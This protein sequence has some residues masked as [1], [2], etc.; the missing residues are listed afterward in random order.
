MD[1]KLLKSQND[2]VISGMGVIILAVWTVVKAAMY[3]VLRL[4]ELWGTLEADYRGIVIAVSAGVIALIGAVSLLLR[5]T[6]GRSAIREGKGGKSGKLYI[7]LA[8]IILVLDGLG[9]LIDLL[10]FGSN[11]ILD[12]VAVLAVD[13]TSAATLIN[14]LVSAKRIRNSAGKAGET[15]CS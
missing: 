2:L 15:V 7:V 13:V 5:I 6:I 3:A 8:W 4:R 11:G 1:R 12:S 10:S 9:V 14:L